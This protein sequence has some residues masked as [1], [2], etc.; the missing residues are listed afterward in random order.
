MY[1]TRS[2]VNEVKIDYT[3]DW[4]KKHLN[5]IRNNYQKTRYFKE[6]FSI[7][8]ENIEK[9]FVYLSDLNISLVLSIAEYLN[10]PRKT[11]QSSSLEVQEQ[12]KNLRLIHICKSVGITH[13]YD[14]EK[15]KEFLDLALFKAHGI[16]V[17]FQIY[18]H[19]T[20]KQCY[21]PFVSH[22]SVIDLLFGY[23]KESIELITHAH[24][25]E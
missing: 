5:I 14:G 2:K 19:P 10:I 23:G 8:Q 18:K 24:A 13:F 15:A 9:R 22:L 3:Q 1:G 11:M 12:D 21:E 25:P 20:Y 17:E 16:E 7:I 6:V 4:I